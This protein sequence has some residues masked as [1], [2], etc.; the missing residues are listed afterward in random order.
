VL[1]KKN[2]N[3]VCTSRA[4][5]AAS[6]EG[7]ETLS[8]HETMKE[9]PQNAFKI[10]NEEHVAG[11]ESKKQTA[12]KENEKHCTDKSQS[13]SYETSRKKQRLT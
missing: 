6:D 2:A 3:F 4:T 11:D 7:N 10:V 1:D 8:T 13:S 12:H 5:D 9:T